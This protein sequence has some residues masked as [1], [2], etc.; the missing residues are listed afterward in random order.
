MPYIKEFSKYYFLNFEEFF[1]VS[2]TTTEK[3][4][5]VS[6]IFLKKHV[7]SQIHFPNGSL[8]KC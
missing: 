2:C 5:L 7:N 6:L 4:S 3:L 8:A 1:K